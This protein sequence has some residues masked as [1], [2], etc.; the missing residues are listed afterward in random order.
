[1]NLRILA[2][3]VTIAIGECACNCT[4]ENHI[5]DKSHDH[6]PVLYQLFTDLKPQK[7]DSL[8]ILKY[9]NLILEYTNDIARKTHQ[10]DSLIEL[11]R[12]TKMSNDEYIM[13]LSHVAHFLGNSGRIDSAEKTLRQ[14]YFSAPSE[15]LSQSYIEY[16]WNLEM[17]L[18]K[19]K[20]NDCDS[21]NYFGNVLQHTINR[22][23][24]KLRLEEIRTAENIIDLLHSEC[25]N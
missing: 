5:A 14:L 18:L 8:N 3:V 13:L 25:P 15:N 6:D 24:T 4:N 11:L 7:P 12:G 10:L 20:D 21:A 17:A 23:S 1:M 22:D 19:L 2:L 16:H 9:N